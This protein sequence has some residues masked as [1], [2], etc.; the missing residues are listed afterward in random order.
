MFQRCFSPVTL[1][2]ELCPLGVNSTCILLGISTFY[3]KKYFFK[4]PLRWLNA[5]VAVGPTTP[6]SVSSSA[7]SDE[8]IKTFPFWY[9]SRREIHPSSLPF[10]LN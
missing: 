4:A 1:L 8:S 2:I 10:F 9:R 7:T 5:N 6:H 3:I